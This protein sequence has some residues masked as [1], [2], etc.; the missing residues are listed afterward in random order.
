MTAV[1]TSGRVLDV[2]VGPAGA[3]KTTA[4]RGLRRRL[5]I[6]AR[7]G[8]GSWAS[9]PSAAAAQVLAD[10]LEIETENLSMWW[11]RHRTT[12]NSF[13]AGQLVI[14]DEASLAGTAMLDRIAHAASEAGAKLLLIGD[15]AQLQAVDAGG[16]FAMLVNDREH[17]PELTDIRRFHNQWEVKHP[18]T[19]G[20]DANE[21]IDAYVDHDRVRGGTI[22]EMTQTAYAAWSRDRAA[23]LVTV[24]ISDGARLLRN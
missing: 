12:G 6:A 14:V 19:F 5:G 1:A 9:R 22:E 7:A 16:A 20:T 10:D 13:V 17:A 2:L 18:S 15:F 3:G 4:M 21:A 11:Q 24:L 23:G 8:L